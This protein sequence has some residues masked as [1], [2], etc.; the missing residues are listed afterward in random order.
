M[1]F[2]DK[3]KLHSTSTFKYAYLPATKRVLEFSPVEGY[4]TYF[5]TDFTYQDL[6][7]VKTSPGPRT[8]TVFISVR[9]TG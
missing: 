4:D 7:F 6:G 5:A 9:S 1:A 8:H 2:L 3:Q